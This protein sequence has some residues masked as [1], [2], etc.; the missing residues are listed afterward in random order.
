MWFRLLWIV[1]LFIIYR[2]AFFKR[3]KINH[4]LW[5]VLLSKLRFLFKEMT[6]HTIELLNFWMLLIIHFLV[7]L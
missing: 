5:L 6:K 7:L 2:Q 4:G 1:L 3:G